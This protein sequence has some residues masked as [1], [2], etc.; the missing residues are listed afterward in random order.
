MR[1]TTYILVVLVPVRWSS[2]LS[3]ALSLPA[4]GC[5][6]LLVV[7]VDD[8]N[9][10]KQPAFRTHPTYGYHYGLFGSHRV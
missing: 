9:R 7:R 4:R 8:R 2:R 10:E 3:R 1:P 6:L 5:P